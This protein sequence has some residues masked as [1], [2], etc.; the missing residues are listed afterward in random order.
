MNPYQQVS[1]LSSAGPTVTSVGLQSNY[2]SG[3]DV[4]LASKFYAI[5]PISVATSKTKRCC[6]I[7]ENPHTA[8]FRYASKGRSHSSSF[9]I[10]ASMTSAACSALEYLDNVSLTSSS[11]ADDSLQGQK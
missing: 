2:V 9:T 8:S 11:K 10:H 7:A 5:N 4:Y 6:V 1:S 3:A